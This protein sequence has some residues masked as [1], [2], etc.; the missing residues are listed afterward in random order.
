MCHAITQS[1]TWRPQAS[2][3]YPTRIPCCRA[4]SASSARSLAASAG[5]SIAS[6]ETF[7]HT[8]RSRVPSSS[9]SSSLRRALS[10]LRRRIGS[11]IASKSRNGC[12]ATISTPRSAAT[13]R[14][15][16]GRPLKKV[17]SFSKSSTVRKPALAAAATLT[18]SD[19]PMQTVAIDHLSIRLPFP[20][21]R[22][23]YRR[24]WDRQIC[25][26]DPR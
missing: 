21:R 25:L 9:I 23:R 19:P 2:A 11:G 12:S 14:A 6:G 24:D 16:R 5:S 20:C 18:S 17:R 10:K 3:S 8:Q 1:L 4:M 26:F 15:S 13:R 22:R 7:E